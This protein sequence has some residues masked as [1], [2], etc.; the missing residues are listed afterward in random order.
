MNILQIH[1]KKRL[2]IGLLFFLSY[3][4]VTAQTGQQIFQQNC[5]SCHSFDRVITGP[6]LRGVTERGPWAE[7][8]KNL[9]AWI[10]NAPAFIPT[11]KYTQD[12]QKL[13]G[14]LMTN[15]SSTL[16]DKDVDAVI[17]YLKNPPAPVTPGTP[18]TGGEETDNGN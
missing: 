12:L 6:A 17:D 16:S 4:T 2:L 1:A 10:H 3:H 13:Y 7:D 15:F 5:A 14:S 9:H 18:K 8:I 11:T